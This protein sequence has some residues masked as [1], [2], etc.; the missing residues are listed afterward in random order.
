MEI[1]LIWAQDKMGG[2]GKNGKLPWHI[3]EDLQNFKKVTLNQTVIMGRKTWDSLPI[4]PLPNRHNIVISRS[5]QKNVTTYQSY[6]ECIKQLNK[7]NIE[8][9]FIIGGRSLYKLFF[10]NAK[11]LH[12]TNIQLIEKGIKYSSQ[13][14]WTTTAEETFK[15]IINV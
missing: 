11:Y 10:D 6:N 8:K 1:H 12:I 15:L 5:L 14:S 2:I 9:A 7:N 3:T 4:K 13:F